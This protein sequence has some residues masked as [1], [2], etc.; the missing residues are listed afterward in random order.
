MEMYDSPSSV[1][2]T[3]RIATAIICTDVTVLTTP[4]VTAISFGTHTAE[5]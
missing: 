3:F 5:T 4:T 1:K 2:A